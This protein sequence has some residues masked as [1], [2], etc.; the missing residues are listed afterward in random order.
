MK[1]ENIF[2]AVLVG[3]F[4]SILIGI[5][6]FL[7]SQLLAT[8]ANIV[9][10]A[11]ATI[12]GIIT[13]VLAYAFMEPKTPVP[14]AQPAQPA[15]PTEEERLGQEIT[16]LRE[17]IKKLRMAQA[18]LV[19]Q[20]DIDGLAQR[21]RLAYLQA[22]RNDAFFDRKAEIARAEKTMKVLGLENSIKEAVLRDD[23]D[24]AQEL[25]SQLEQLDKTRAEQLRKQLN[26]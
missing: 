7:T 23:K 3:I 26:I 17:G 24:T 25:L 22:E 15:P 13:T 10:V 14:S 4:T 20:V 21:L 2:V 19:T 16:D 8:T 6:G 12:A 9:L 11:I 18:P 1:K 5:V